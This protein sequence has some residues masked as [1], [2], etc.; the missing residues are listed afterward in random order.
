MGSEE[1]MWFLPN[2]IFMGIEREYFTKY[3]IYIYDYNYMNSNHVEYL[4]YN[5]DYI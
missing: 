3:I 1:L 5:G 2:A 4:W